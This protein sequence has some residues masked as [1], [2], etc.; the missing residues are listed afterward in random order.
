ME[1]ELKLEL[2]EKLLQV[3]EEQILLEIKS[4]LDQRPSASSISDELYSELMKRRENA[5]TN[6][7][8]LFSWEE[9][10]NELLKK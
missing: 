9:V 7:T 3:S 2:I 10:K 1:N 8:K 5:L 6:N 4:V